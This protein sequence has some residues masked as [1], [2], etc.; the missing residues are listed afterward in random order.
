MSIYD[1]L[2]ALAA[3][4]LTRNEMKVWLVYRA[5]M[6][7]GARQ[8]RG[9]TAETLRSKT[10]LGRA[11][12]AAASAGLQ[13]KGIIETRRQRNAAQIIVVPELVPECL[14]IQD[15]R[16]SRSSGKPGYLENPVSGSPGNPDAG[17]PGN[18]DHDIYAAPVSTPKTAPSARESCAAP[19]VDLDQLV[20]ACNGALDNPANCMGLLTSTVPIMWL[21][22]GCDLER[23]IIPTL[24]A[25]GRKH[26]GKRIRSWDYFT[27][28]VTDARDRRLRGLPPP[29]AVPPKQA[30]RPAYLVPTRRR[31]ETEDELMA[32]SLSQMAKFEATA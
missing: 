30:P 10:D 22:S 15:V 11:Q 17:S 16:K 7:E 12:F 9:K 6:D 28:A 14:D 1:E 23:D 4:D 24:E 19:K 25:A 21:E 26:H 18:P 31:E 29:T 2:R 5:E 20:K 3:L 13:A 8:V 27:G 32:W